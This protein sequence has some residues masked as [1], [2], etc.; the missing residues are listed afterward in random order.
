MTMKMR[1][2][3]RLVEADQPEDDGW[4]EARQHGFTPDDDWYHGTSRPIE[5][6]DPSLLGS[7]TDARN[8]VL[9]FFFTSDEHH[10]GY[11]AG[12]R[13]HV[14]DAVL[15]M[16]KPFQIAVP[17][18]HAAEY[19]DVG[20]FLDEYVRDDLGLRTYPTAEDFREFKEYL[21]RQ[22]Y[23]SIIVKQLDGHRVAIVFNANQIRER[24]AAF[25][26][27]KLDSDHLYH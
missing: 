2:I 19:N 17:S 13:G 25:D 3:M 27:T 10:A 14:V 22:G 5:R 23:D 24:E 20:H 8:T 4:D 26:P 7:T 12:K 21:I 6:F 18:N 11:Y 15:R 9:G 1:D 16:R